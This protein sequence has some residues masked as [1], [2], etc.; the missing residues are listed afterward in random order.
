[1]N[2]GIGL[3]GKMHV[4]PQELHEII[5]SIPISRPIDELPITEFVNRAKNKLLGGKII[6]SVLV[7]QF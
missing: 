3:N 1:M 5:G 6:Y 2:G 7:H 4:T